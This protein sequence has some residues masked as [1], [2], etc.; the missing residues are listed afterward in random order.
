MVDV[1][2]TT[3]W[4]HRHF[5][6]SLGFW[7]VNVFKALVYFHPDY[8]ELQH[9]EFRRL[10]AHALLTE[11]QPL[12][13][14]VDKEPAVSPTETIAEGHQWCSFAKRAFDE[15]RDVPKSGEMHRSCGYCAAKVMAYGRVLPSGD[16]A[17]LRHLRAVHRSQL[18]AAALQWRRALPRHAQARQ[19]GQ[20]GASGGP[21]R[22]RQLS[23]QAPREFMISVHGIMTTGEC[24]ELA[25]RCDLGVS[26]AVG[27]VWYR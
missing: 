25:S 4:W 15:G 22:R 26:R 1:W 6:E 11:G 20:G 21:R 19:G 14:D 13:I 12:V 8:K 16:E 7:E 23:G 24:N 17:N 18:H 5:A 2:E 27:M 3:R 9:P 10:L